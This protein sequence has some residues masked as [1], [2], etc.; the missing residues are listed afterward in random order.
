MWWRQA[1]LVASFSSHGTI[2]QAKMVQAS[3]LVVVSEE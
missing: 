2:E 3:F 1:R